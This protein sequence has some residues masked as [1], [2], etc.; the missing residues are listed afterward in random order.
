MTYLREIQPRG[1]HSRP[2]PTNLQ[3]GVGMLAVGGMSNA[4]IAAHLGNVYHEVGVN[5][6]RQLSRRLNAV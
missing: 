3:E 4:Q 1:K 2:R 5:S 6:R